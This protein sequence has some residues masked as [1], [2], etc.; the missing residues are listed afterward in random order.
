MPCDTN[1]KLN[2][3]INRNKNSVAFSY[4][5]AAYLNSHSF[6]SNEEPAHRFSSSAFRILIVKFRVFTLLYQTILLG[7]CLEYFCVGI[8]ILLNECLPFKFSF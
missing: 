6:Q 3:S 8:S 4:D 2:K 7:N 1:V 5:H